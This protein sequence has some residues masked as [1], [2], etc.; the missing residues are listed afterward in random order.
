MAILIL[1]EPEELE[2]LQRM[3]ARANSASVQTTARAKRRDD[4]E[5]K[6]I[7]KLNKKLS[8]TTL[9]QPIDLSRTE[10]RFIQELFILATKTILDTVIPNYKKRIKDGG[11]VNG[12]VAY[13]QAAEVRVKTY[14]KI[15][16][17]LNSVL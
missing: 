8:T 16:D 10:V 1:D 17:K 4:P 11:E 12:L 3:I 15:L 2:Q 13:I 7:T 5:L 9:H 14:K 6:V